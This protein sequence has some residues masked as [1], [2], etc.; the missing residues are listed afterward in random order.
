[1]ARIAQLFYILAVSTTVF[2]QAI[3]LSGT[4]S[5]ANGKAIVGAHVTLV[6][7]K[8]VV[9]T[10][11]AGLFRIVSEVSNETNV[12]Q[13]KENDHVEIKN[14]IVLLHLTAPSPVK[15]E[16]FDFHGKLMK[17]IDMNV[18]QPGEYRF[19]KLGFNN[20]ATMS[21]LRISTTSIVK[22]FRWLSL[23]N[24]PLIGCD[25]SAI[26]S[27]KVVFSNVVAPVDSLKISAAGYRSKTVPLLSYQNTHVTI[28][29]DTILYGVFRIELF[30][31][32]IQTG[33]PAYTRVYGTINDGPAPP[34]I[35]F[36]KVE[37]SG[38]CKL[39]KTIIPF[40]VNCNL[41]GKC[42]ADDS[43]QREPSPVN[44]GKVTVIGLKSNGIKTSFTMIPSK[45]N[46]YQ[47]VEK[48]DFPPFSEGDSIVLQAEG[49]ATI[50][51]ITVKTRGVSPLVVTNEEIVFEDGKPVTI[52]W[53]K[54]AIA[55]VSA[56]TIRINVSYHGGTK[57]EIIVDC[58]DNGEVTVP[59]SMIDKLKSWGIAG[60]P[61]AE[62][63]RLSIVTI[64]SMNPGLIIQSTKIKLITIPGLE[65]CDQNEDCT[66]GRCID[67]MCR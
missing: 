46:Y 67:R 25:I 37:E 60:Y 8:Y 28:T 35:I 42:V 56:M 59:A 16:Q 44:V 39:F 10:D 54:P 53:Q 11:S 17:Q 12:P 66:T 32:D 55:G 61:V 4:V 38:P 15:F 30:P 50:P 18:V 49:T 29:L 3:S 41:G 65:N 63:T 33:D 9:D 13:Y 40:C 21:A 36:E 22:T 14:S 45:S 31:A 64:D 20:A 19:E 48:P 51:P 27:G 5:N 47:L 23:E 2:P 62:L 24:K 26:T 6:K 52:K 43:C 7:Q 57:G 34:G 58:E 1:M